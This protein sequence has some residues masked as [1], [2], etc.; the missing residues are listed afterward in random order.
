MSAVKEAIF[1]CRMG[2]LLGIYWDKNSCQKPVGLTIC[3][4]LDIVLGGI[5]L[6]SVYILSYV[7]NIKNEIEKDTH[8]AM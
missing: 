4:Q 5:I 8:S 1:V 2:I 3:D 7:K 6:Q